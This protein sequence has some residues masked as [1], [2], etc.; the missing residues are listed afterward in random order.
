LFRIG[1]RFILF[2]ASESNTGYRCIDSDDGAVDAHER[3]DDRSD[4]R[5]VDGDHRGDVVDQSA[6]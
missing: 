3:N 1:I 4:E 2:A 5:D 6:E